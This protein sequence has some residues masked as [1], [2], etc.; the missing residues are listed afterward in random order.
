MK[1][2]S[3]KLFKLLP[4][5]LFT[6]TWKFDYIVKRGPS[7]RDQQGSNYRAKAVATARFSSEMEAFDFAE[8]LRYRLGE[9]GEVRVSWTD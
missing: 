2:Q 9:K 8:V 3:L 5:L 4:L 7:L 6:V 1:P